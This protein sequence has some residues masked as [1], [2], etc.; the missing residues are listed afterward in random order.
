MIGIGKTIQS[1]YIVIVGCGRVGANIASMASTA[2]HNVVVIDK[3]ENAFENLSVEYTG[4]TILGDATERDVLAQAKV[5]KADLV[6]VL[7]DDDNTNYL[8]SMAC[9]YYFAVQNVISR[10]YEPDN[11]ML[12]QE[13]GIKVVSPT[14][15]VI[16][17][18]TH[19]VAG[20]KI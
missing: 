4:F 1:L 18:L 15:L 3:V 9:K 17:E 8:V 5:D 19:I 13:S 14:L 6:L 16:G 20:D 2:G 10:V 12:F 11:V 7:T